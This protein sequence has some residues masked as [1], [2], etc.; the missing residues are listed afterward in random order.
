VRR[1]ELTMTIVYRLVSE[2]SEESSRMTK[3]PPSTVSMVLARRFG[4]SASK[5]CPNKHIISG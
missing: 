2:D 4:V 5:S 1:I 3:P